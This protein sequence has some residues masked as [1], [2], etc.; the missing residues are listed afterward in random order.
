MIP[1]EYR[2]TEYILYIM[3]IYWSYYRDYNN[4]SERFTQ[5]AV[6]T[7]HQNLWGSRWG[8]VPLSPREGEKNLEAKVEVEDDKSEGNPEV[9]N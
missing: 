3:C 5:Q 7:I 9:P 4:L 2:A 1:I 6:H 8:V